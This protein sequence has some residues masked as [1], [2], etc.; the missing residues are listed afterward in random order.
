MLAA[1]Y[2]SLLAPALDLADELGYGT[3]SFVPAV[4][5]V[6]LGA[7]FVL[8]TERCLPHTHDP[9]AYVNDEEDSDAVV[10]PPDNIPAEKVE[11]PDSL[12]L[13]DVT[14]V[15]LPSSTVEVSSGGDPTEGFAGRHWSKEFRRTMLL[16]LAVTVH[17]FPE[18]L[19][20]GVAFG[21]IG[22]VPSA[23]FENAVSL[24]IGIG[25]QNFPEGMVQW[26]LKRIGY[27]YSAPTKTK[28]FLAA[29][30]AASL[31]LHWLFFC[32]IDCLRNIGRADVI[33]E[34]QFK[35]C[36]LQGSFS[37]AN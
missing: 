22:T 18:G 37:R 27:E 7:G 20:V 26:L 31:S 19:A 1:S 11:I 8:A 35:F 33:S 15:T 21:A 3:Y 9:H 6:L 4:V 14:P 23:T 36:E 34:A 24:A 12:E 30:P 29:K 13:E 28:S 16:V 32:L 2:W 25:I 17:N 10:G 5:G